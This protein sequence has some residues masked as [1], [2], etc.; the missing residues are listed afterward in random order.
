[1]SLDPGN[2]FRRT[3]QC[4]FRVQMTSHMSS[5]YRDMF[6][7]CA[8]ALLC[9]AYVSHSEPLTCKDVLQPLDELDPN[10]LQGEWAM[11]AGS[12]R[13]IESDEPFDIPDSVSLNFYN[14]TFTKGNLYGESCQYLSR[15][16]LI[17]DAQYN[18]TVGQMSNFSG[19]IFRTSCTDCVVLSFKVESPHFKS[20]E[21]CL[22][23]KRREMDEKVLKEFATQAECLKLPKIRVMDPTKHLC[24]VHPTGA[25]G[26][27]N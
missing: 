19:T 5:T 17:K 6:A 16:V 2:T 27:S 13:V 8:I 25:S 12:L 23:S 15:D 4:D 26:S 7:V 3:L 24:P 11:V 21:L 10:D 9:L 22:F 18:F 1:M 14:S 20:E